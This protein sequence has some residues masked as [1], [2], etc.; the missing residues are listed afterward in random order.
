MYLK[1]IRARNYR[2]FGD[3]S[4]VPELD[5]E[6]NPG[7]NILVGEND[8]GKSCIVDA[9]RQVLLT[10]SYEN[11]RLFEQDFHIHGS[12]RSNTLCI[13][14][15]LCG[16]S[17][18]QEASVLEWLTLGEDGNCSLILNLEARFHLPQATK[19][20]RV[21]TIV[22]TGVNGSGPEVGYAVREL[23]R[24]TYLKPLRDAEA[25]L[26]SGRH[27]RLSQILGAHNHIAGQEV[28]DFDRALP[29][30]IPS[31]L[32]GLM[33]FTQHHLG[34]HHVIKSVEKD[35]NDNYLS[36]FAFS[37]DS[38]QSR[39]RIAPDLALT[40]ILEKFELSL[41]PGAHI[42][43]DARCTRGLGYNNALFMATELVLLRDGE[44]LGLLLVEEPEA[45]LH[46]QLQERVMDLFKEHSNGNHEQKRV[47]VIM[48]TH[49]P[50]LV[51]TARIEDMT[52]VHRAQTFPLAAGKTKL[53]R[54]DYS[55]LRRFID[56]TKAN[57]FFARGVMMVEG[58]A[59]SILLPAI[60]EMCGR[61][62]SEHGVSLVNVGNTGLY[63]YAR[64]LQREGSGP[65]IPIP[66]VCLTDRDIVPDVAKA[67]V[68]TPA[69]GKR[70]DSDYDVAEIALTVQ[71][72]KERA[73][74][75][76]TIV[77]VSDRWTLEYDLALYGCAKL[78]YLAITLAV[79]AKSRDERLEESDEIATL[80]T[81]EAQWSILEA[82]GHNAETLA[83]II[84]QPLQEK[85]ASKAIA[86]QYAAY[87]VCTG[88][89]GK[90]EELFNKLPPYLQ[91]ALLHLTT[92]PKSKSSAMT[93]EGSDTATSTAASNGL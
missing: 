1:H 40:P 50:S 14:A 59:E 80:A 58:P 29:G 5:W 91:T 88:A 21:E 82:A 52:L 54:T 70:F 89:Y 7:L 92:V 3:N 36:Q 49:S 46:P 11:I 90:N 76:K 60:A 62:F 20:S 56:A 85:D 43:P 81:A 32:V 6:L 57:L 86:A 37:G 23:V 45:H 83:A 28:N 13:E 17:V 33:A 65:D 72:K 93:E 55:F 24:A 51:S 67:Y 30:N 41:L 19:R 9:I 66:V 42:D 35:I 10:T 84:Y 12:I 8:A 61:S 31:R 48:T 39:I 78:M 26:S 79:K 25:E 15:T 38:I 87:L 2:A 47:Q 44:E 34:Q 4:S 53:K 74:G 73:E 71:R 18:D 16:L 27:S 63:H 69:K 77:C 68:S 75:G 22:R 64:I